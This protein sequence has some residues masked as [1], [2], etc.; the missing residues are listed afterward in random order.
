MLFDIDYF[1]FRCFISPDYVIER[2]CMVAAGMREVRVCGVVEQAYAAV[3]AG[4]WWSAARR[5]Q[6]GMR[7]RESPSPFGPSP[8]SPHIH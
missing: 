7:R 8:P 3:A 4:R 6:A 5:R 1:S 2:V